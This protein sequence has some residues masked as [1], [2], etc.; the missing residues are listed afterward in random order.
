MVA[1]GSSRTTSEIEYDQYGPHLRGTFGEKIYFS[2]AQLNTSSFLALA[3]APPSEGFKEDRVKETVLAK[4][5]PRI[6]KSLPAYQGYFTVDGNVVGHCARVQIGK[7]TCL[8]TAYHVLSYNRR[9]DLMLNANG[10]SIRF[11][12]VRV[13]PVYFSSESDLDY[14]AMA[15]PDVIF[16]KLGMKQAKL[17]SHITYGSPVSINQIIDGQTCYTVGLAQ[18][19]DKPWMISYAATTV[20]GTSGAP[21]L[22]VRGE[23]VGVHIEGGKI[24]NVG[25]V[26]EIFRQKKESAQNGDLFAEDPSSVE[27]DDALEAEIEAELDYEEFRDRHILQY[28]SKYAEY[29]SGQNWGD[30]MDDLE[31]AIM[32]N[33][34]SAEDDEGETRRLGKYYQ[35]YIMDD[36]RGQHIGDRIKGDRFRKKESPWTCSRCMALH[37]NKGFKCMNC[38]YA[39]KHGKAVKSTVKEVVDAKKEAIST[40]GFPTVVEDKIIANIDDMGKRMENLEWLVK[41]HLSEN[42]KCSDCEIKQRMTKLPKEAVVTNKLVMPLLTNY[43]PSSEKF[44]TSSPIAADREGKQIAGLYEKGDMF[45]IGKPVSEIPIKITVAQ[46]EEK[47][48]KKRK[49]VRKPKKESGKKETAA[50]EAPAVH[51]N[52]KSPSRGG[53]TT[54]NGVNL[55]N[56]QNDQRS[57]VT[58]L[59][60]STQLNKQ[61]KASSGSKPKSSTQV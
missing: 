43:G 39:L 52:S 27:A 42:K 5:Q 41:K 34:F 32:E 3:T 6:T 8:L 30:M 36:K 47:D 61:K 50:I 55:N 19:A 26:P 58:P 56:S 44:V 15:V 48:K 1:M 2:R 14:I 13:T 20:E 22:N 53:V 7:K 59:V 46:K 29:H 31:E 49:R 11:S 21:I 24:A 35:A 18:K 16:S 54:T 33:F 4:S 45:P 17:A 38:G 51:L 12:D 60:S 10:K 37:L 23:I 40:L 28:A 25:V 57:S 9:A